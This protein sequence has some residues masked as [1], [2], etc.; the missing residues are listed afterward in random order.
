MLKSCAGRL[1]VEVKEGGV[2]TLHK[3]AAPG[4]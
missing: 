3:P 4:T 1:G 2:E